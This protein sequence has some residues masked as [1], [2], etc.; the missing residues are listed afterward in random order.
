MHCYQRFVHAKGLCLTPMPRIAATVRKRSWH[1]RKSYNQKRNLDFSV[2]HRDKTTE[3]YSSNLLSP[4][5]VSSSRTDPKCSKLLGK[6]EKL[7]KRV[8]RKWRNI[9]DSCK[10]H[11]SNAPRLTTPNFFLSL[12]INHH[13]KENTSTQLRTSNKMS[14]QPLQ[15]SRN[16]QS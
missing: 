10:L 1:S 14:R 8:T 3:W 2:R 15:S 16:S 5:W 6:P 11:H 12:R 7:K 4:V 9:N 13:W